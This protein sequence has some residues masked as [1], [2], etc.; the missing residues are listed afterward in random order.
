MIRRSLLASA[1]ARSVTTR[2]GPVKRLSL[3]SV[4]VGGGQGG[5]DLRGDVERVPRLGLVVRGRPRGSGFGTSDEADAVGTEFWVPEVQPEPPCEPALLRPRVGHRLAGHRAGNRGD[6]PPVHP[7]ARVEFADVVQQCGS[8]PARV[9]AVRRARELS[10]DLARD[11]DGV[12]TVVVRLQDPQRIGRGREHR[13]DP[14]FVRRPRCHRRERARKARGEMDDFHPNTNRTRALANGDRMRPANPVVN[15]RMNSTR[16][17]YGWNR[18][19]PGSQSFGRIRAMIADPSRGGIGTRLNSPR[20]RFTNAKENRICTPSGRSSKPKPN[21]TV[22]GSNTALAASAEIAMSKKL[23]AGPA[24]LTTS[25]SRRGSRMRAGF[26]GTG[27]AHASTGTPSSAPIAGITID[28]T[29]SMC[30]IGFSVRRPAR[31]AVSSP[32]HDATTP[33]LT[34]WKITATMRHAKNTTACW[35][36]VFTQGGSAALGSAVDAEP[37]GRH[38]L[39]ASVCD[40]LVTALALA[41]GTRVELRE[42][43]L[44]LGERL[45]ELARDGLDLTPFGSDL[46]GV[47]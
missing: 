31:F 44:D 41:V 20:N 42:C 17:P 14:R 15:T 2:A 1:S 39:E 8:D 7:E 6:N 13:L 43:V 33:W 46:P 9:V 19:Q 11:A 35:K 28:P 3:F 12:P 4:V 29:G 25:M 34:S 30:G 26:T 38:R 23:V 32:N 37:S 21:G 36:S 16:K 5:G 45:I 10:F 27:L 22:L 40:A 18:Y 24:R 47:G